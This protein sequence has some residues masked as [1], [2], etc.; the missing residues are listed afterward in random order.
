MVENMNKEKI[1][2]V[3][4][5]LSRN[6]S[7]YYGANSKTQSW[8]EESVRLYAETIPGD[9]Y[10]RLNQESASCLFMPTFFK[11]DRDRSLRILEEEHGK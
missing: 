10:A 5:T 1:Q 2:S 6:R 9:L 8:I 11:G 4:N 7:E 3:Y